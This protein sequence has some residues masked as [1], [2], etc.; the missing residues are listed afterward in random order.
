MNNIMIKGA[1]IHNLKGFDISIPKNKITVATGVSGSGKSSLM[2]DII[3][4]E[5][6]KQYLQSLGIFPGLED[7]KKFDSITGVSPTISVRQSLVRQ[8]N[9]RSTVGSRTR[10]LSQ[11]AMLY[12][13]EGTLICPNC[14]TPL[15]KNLQCSS[16]DYKG[17]SLDVSYFSYNSPNGMCKKCFGKGSYSKVNMNKLVSNKSIT[18]RQV[19]RNAGTTS[20]IERVLDRN[21]HKYM[22]LPYYK[23]PDEIKNEIKNGHYTSNSGANNKSYCLSRILEAR[24]KKGEFIGDLY[25]P[26]SCSACNGYRIGEE[27]RSVLINGK[28]FG[29]LGKMTLEQTRDFLVQTLQEIE[30]TQL[31]KTLAQDIINKLSSLI[32]SRLGHLT[33]YREMST[34]S[35]G[36]IQRIFLNAHLESN[37]DSLI[38]VL[39]EPTTG[40]HEL[41]KEEL[42]KSIKR[43]KDLGNTV[44]IVEHDRKIIQVAEHIVDIGP[45][46]GIAGGEVIYE[47]D[48][49]GLLQCDK[50]LTGQYLSDTQKIMKRNLK[51]NLQNDKTT[52]WISIKH[53]KTNNLK[54]VSVSFPLGVL[55]GIAGV[56]GS[57]K[58]SLI[59]DTLVPMLKDYFRNY[60]KNILDCDESDED[61]ALVETIAETILGAESISGF[62]EVSQAPIGRNINSSPVT[63]IKIWDKIRN[64]FASQEKSIELG[65]T[66]GHFSFNSDGACPDCSGSGRKSVFPGS[67]IQ[68]YTTCNTC[69]G[70]RYNPEALQVTYKGKNISEI[71]DMQISEAV[72]L[73]EDN[74]PIVHTLTIMKDIGMGYIKLGQP[75][76]TLSGGEAQRLKL[77]KEIGKK[78]KGNILYVMDEPTTG[79]SMYDTAQLI[80][81]LN[82]L[83]E[84]GN[85]VLIIEHNI[86]VLKSCDWIVELGPDGGVNGGTVIAKGSPKDLED[87][88]KSITG[89]YLKERL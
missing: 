49:A 19:F 4:E 1:R 48:Y 72:S 76:S 85:S 73:F 20:G 12:H 42:L 6:R 59:S 57:G 50:S 43:L 2:F 29:E 38:Y 81:L 35:G 67:N 21:L 88:P 63:F 7:D 23:V 9:P 56:S 87:N 11:L 55:V 77:A 47:G 22:D 36:E 30:F 45:K 66:A 60:S 28:H 69:K 37:M 31:G 34:L 68:M 89:K 51:P 83:I 80:K 65:L 40:L 17:H 16:C 86:D 13:S 26:I 62:A 10:L 15:G 46:A 33:M 74:K 24:K 27:A 53:A 71:L 32:D 84:N 39:D 61:S 14:G 75:T 52:S 58:S 79:L 70:K 8:S 3:F 64:L 5:G 18:V 78:R 44:I 54:D 82:K 41:E 25:R